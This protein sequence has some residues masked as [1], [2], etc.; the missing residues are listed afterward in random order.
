MADTGLAAT[1]AEAAGAPI[2]TSMLPDPVQLE[3]FR[4]PDGKLSA[5]SINVA[6]GRGRPAGARNKRQKKIADYFVQRYGDPLDVLGQIMTTPTKQLVEVLMEADGSAEREAR[7]FAM[8]EE[9]ITHIK[10]L[11]R[12]GGDT[13]ESA[14]ELSDAIEKLANAAK[15]ISGRPGKLALD[16]LIVQLGAAKTALEYV[17]GKQPI[18]ID[19]TGKADL[20]IF[21]PEIM[22]QNGVD[23]IALHKAISERGLEAFDSETMQIA[24]PKDGE[25]EPVDD[26]EG[27]A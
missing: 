10:S 2:G 25:F 12:L 6:R 17:H 19:V 26:G 15:S 23:P 22:R 24:P 16:T 8:V 3:A 4:A 5:S 7:L 9:A 27:E 13:K 18:S 14:E 1:I 20:V 21:A 11:K